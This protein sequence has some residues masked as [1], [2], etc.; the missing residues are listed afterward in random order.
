MP[1]LVGNPEDQFSRVAAHMRLD[2]DNSSE[3]EG[4]TRISFIPSFL[5]EFVLECVTAIFMKEISKF[6]NFCVTFK[7]FYELSISEILLCS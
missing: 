5:G 4:L 6:R 1:H 3:N 2:L 7:L